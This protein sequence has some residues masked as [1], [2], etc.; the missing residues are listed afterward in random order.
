MWKQFWGKNT[1]HTHT[2]TD[3]QL[4]WLNTFGHTVHLCNSPEP[5]KLLVFLQLLVEV[6]THSLSVWVRQTLGTKK[7]KL[8]RW[9]DLN[10]TTQVL[11]Q[12]NTHTTDRRKHPTESQGEAEKGSYRP[13]APAMTC[14]VGGSMGWLGSR[15]GLCSCSALVFAAPEAGDE[16]DLIVAWGTRT[17]AG[18]G[19]WLRLGSVA[20]DRG[21]RK[22]RNHK[23]AALQTRPCT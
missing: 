16:G 23:R 3:T 19:T 5:Q 10:K 21:Q 13:G 22:E 6:L 11:S 17:G 20:D 4:R 1:T 9:Q 8:S 7:P 18:L 15:W 14:R 2:E 12:C